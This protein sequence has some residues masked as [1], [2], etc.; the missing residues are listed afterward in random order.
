M[1]SRVL[2]NVEVMSASGTPVRKPKESSKCV[3]GLVFGEPE[4]NNITVVE[5]T[6]NFPHIYNLL[7][8]EKPAL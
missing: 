8:L 4:K 1:W 5:I 2:Q 3:F 7:H 6:S